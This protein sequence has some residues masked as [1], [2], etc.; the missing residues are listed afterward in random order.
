MNNTR[1]PNVRSLAV[2]RYP[3]TLLAQSVQKFHLNHG[4][5]VSVCNATRTV[6]K[7]PTFDTSH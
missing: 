4:A 6:N 1:W 7:S 2:S 3:L 5:L